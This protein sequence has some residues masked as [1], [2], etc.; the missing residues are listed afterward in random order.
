MGACCSKSAA[1]SGGLHAANC[2]LTLLITRSAFWYSL[3]KSA[4]CHSGL[5]LVVAIRR[6]ERLFCVAIACSGP[7]QN[8]LGVGVNRPFFAYCNYRTVGLSPDNALWAVD[9]VYQYYG[10]L[11][12]YC[13]HQGIGA[14]PYALAQK[15]GIYLRTGSRC[16]SLFLGFTQN[17][18]FFTLK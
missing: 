10:Y 7:N 11:V 17:I 12:L 8:L 13:Q 5:C 18:W 6:I 15:N 16:A 9:T 1:L 14:Y 3:A 4:C 2:S